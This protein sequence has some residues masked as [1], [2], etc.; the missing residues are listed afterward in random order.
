MSQLPTNPL[1]AA[2]P[3]DVGDRRISAGST[4]MLPRTHVVPRP[5][6]P[7]SL[8]GVGSQSAFCEA[9]LRVPPSGVRLRVPHGPTPLSVRPSRG[10][11]ASCSRSYVRLRGARWPRRLWVVR[12]SGRRQRSHDVELVRPASRSVSRSPLPMQSSRFA[13]GSVLL[14]PRVA[15]PWPPAAQA[16][17]R[18]TAPHRATLRSARR[19]VAAPARSPRSACPAAARWRSPLLVTPRSLAT[20]TAGSAV[21]RSR[22]VAMQRSVIVPSSALLDS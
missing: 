20:S 9:T 3:T 18:R 7:E 6:A 15:V 21:I 17:W 11:A 13:H 10:C 4:S 14:L 22:R 19:P 12:R 16:A 5:L 8:H 1:L 2:L